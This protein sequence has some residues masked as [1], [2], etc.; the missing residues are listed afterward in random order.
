MAQGTAALGLKRVAAVR[1]GGAC[2]TGSVSPDHWA[3]AVVVEE[4]ESGGGGG[5]GDTGGFG[6]SRDGFKHHCRVLPAEEMRTANPY[7]LLTHQQGGFL[8]L[9]NRKPIHGSA[10]QHPIYKILNPPWLSWMS[11]TALLRRR[12]GE[13]DNSEASAALE[14]GSK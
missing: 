1:N 13:E 12:V 2:Y 10:V 9:L 8:G 11:Y 7:A 5:L 6:G 4:A 3:G 14:R